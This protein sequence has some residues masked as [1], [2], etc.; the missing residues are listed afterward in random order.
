LT[1]ES[2]TPNFLKLLVDQSKPPSTSTK[3]ASASDSDPRSG[4]GKGEED[5]EQEE[6]ELDEEKPQIVL[7]KNVTQQEAELHVGNISSSTTNTSSSSSSSVITTKEQGGLGD[8]PKS[9]QIGVVSASLKRKEKL[10]ELVKKYEGEGEGD[11]SITSKKKK[12]KVKNTK[13]LS[14]ETDE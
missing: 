12:T 2:Q 11:S 1:F 7:G 6:E 9:S 13:L 10:N 5:H 3:Y 4:S 8:K 14:F